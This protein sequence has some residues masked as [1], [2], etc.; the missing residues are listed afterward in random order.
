MFFSR[1]IVSHSSGRCSGVWYYNLDLKGASIQEFRFWRA[2]F[3]RHVVGFKSKCECINKMNASWLESCA[4]CY[5]FFLFFKFDKVICPSADVF[6]ESSEIS[7]DGTVFLFAPA[8]ATGHVLCMLGTMWKARLC[9]MYVCLSFFACPW[10]PKKQAGMLGWKNKIMHYAS[11]S[12]SFFKSSDFT[13]N[14]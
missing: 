4:F 9:H 8:E 1:L 3:L 6:E 13:Y 2:P 14:T 10:A 5:L 7:L 11:S 12:S